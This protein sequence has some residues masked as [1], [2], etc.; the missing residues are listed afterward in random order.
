[1][2]FSTCSSFELVNP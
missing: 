2:E 1:M